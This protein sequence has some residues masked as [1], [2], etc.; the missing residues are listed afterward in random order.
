M[1]YYE[2]ENDNEEVA[3][4]DEDSYNYEE[5]NDENTYYGKKLTSRRL[6]NHLSNNFRSNKSNKKL[7]KNNLW[8]D[9]DGNEL[10]SSNSFEFGNNVKANYSIMHSNYN[11][12]NS[13]DMNSHIE[14][15][16]E[17]ELETLETILKTT[18]LYNS[19]SI[20]NATSGNNNSTLLNAEYSDAGTAVINH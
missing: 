4:Y 2:D 13:N 3:D 12:S 17:D 18:H 5:E 14:D 9:E 1:D 6:N 8:W 10:T 16:I 11:I 7:I 15:D 20:G 19:K